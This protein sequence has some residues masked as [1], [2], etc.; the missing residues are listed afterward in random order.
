VEELV[1]AKVVVVPGRPFWTDAAAADAGRG[2]EMLGLRSGW[3]LVPC[4][5]RLAMSFLSLVLSVIALES[6]LMFLAV[7]CLT[8]IPLDLTFLSSYSFSCY[9]NLLPHAL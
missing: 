9:S 1:A 6:V 5:I 8:C 4:I 3:Q 2:L 7:A